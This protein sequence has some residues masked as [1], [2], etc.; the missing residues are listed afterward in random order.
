MFSLTLEMSLIALPINSKDSDIAFLFKLP[1]D[2]LALRSVRFIDGVPELLFDASRKVPTL[3]EEDVA[4]AFRLAQEKKRPEFFY[5]DFPPTHPLFPSRK[6]MQYS[7]GWLRWTGVGK[8][9]A[10]ADWIMKCLHIGARSDEDKTS[11][12]SWS[13]SSNLDG[14]ATR[15]DFPE[16]NNSGSIKMSCEYAKVEMND[17]E[18]WFPEEPKMRIISEPSPLYSKYITECYP[19][20][21]YHDEPKFL[22]VQE[23]IKLVL[24]VEWLYNEKGVRMNQEWVRKHT[25]QPTDDGV[26]ASKEPARDMIP[27]PDKLTKRP[28]SDVVVKTWEAEMYNMLSSKC[29]VKRH[30]GY[31]DFGRAEMLM[32]KEDGTK[33]PP[34]RCLKVY[35]EDFSITDKK[36]IKT[37]KGWIYL[38]MAEP[39]EQLTQIRD[40]FLG[41]LAQNHRSMITYP[42][43]ASVES[44]IDD[45]IDGSTLELKFTNS[46]QPCPSLVLPPMK[47]I[48]IIKATLNDYDK[49]F[50]SEDPNEPIIPEIPGI[51][52]EAVIP[53]VNSWSELIS[54]LTVPSPRVWLHPF[55]GIGTPTAAGGVTTANFEV[56]SQPC[57]KVVCE[58]TRWS[59]DYVYKKNVSKNH[60]LLA[61]R[62]RRVIGML[63]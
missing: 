62:P 41:L 20:I 2:D 33:C 45:R 48:T 28:T 38:P 8:L 15:L 10:D 24:A 22:K 52:E 16:D 3:Q 36:S 54:E 5:R 39:V 53:N 63:E 6:F 21:A 46:F 12:E 27:V 50:A 13:H 34:Q 61:V 31:Y 58:E 32:F 56:R 37:E 19:S 11:F 1:K 60:D 9:L 7:P 4:A 30:Y 40:Y 49:L 26:E 35:R 47:K 51:C 59:D 25:S 14:L 42:I 29:K 18:I 44:T 55:T 57:P 17:D 43:P 23:L